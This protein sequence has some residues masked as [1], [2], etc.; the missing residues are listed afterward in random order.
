MSIGCIPEF[1]PPEVEVSEDKHGEGID[2]EEELKP[3]WMMEAI[4]GGNPTRCSLENR[5]MFHLSKS[6]L[7]KNLRK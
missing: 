7:N 1:C 6:R 5:Q 2:F 3:G 4:F